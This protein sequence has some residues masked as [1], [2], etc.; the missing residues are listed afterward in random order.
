MY[1]LG[2]PCVDARLHEIGVE[3]KDAKPP[4]A[5]PEPKE[6][7]DHTEAR[8]IYQAYLQKVQELEAHQVYAE[9]VARATAGR[10]QTPVRPLATM[11]TDGGPLLCDHCGKPIVLEGGQFHGKTADEAWRVNSS[12]NWTSWILGG[13]VVEIQVNGTLRIYHGYPGRTNHCCNV[14]SRERAKACAEVKSN[15]GAEKQSMILAFLEHE[16]PDMTRNERLGLLSKILGTL[17]S[18]D[19]GIG[20]N[21]P[22]RGS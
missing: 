2:M 18:Y 19:P 3:E 16:F 20:I 14:A 21:R 9:Q 15:P 5:K 10:G 22:S 11:G 13:L 1:Q 8:E 6:A 17:Y 7:R 12:P 4:R